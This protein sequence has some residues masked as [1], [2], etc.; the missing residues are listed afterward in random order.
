M[1]TK[2]RNKIAISQPVSHLYFPRI[3][4]RIVPYSYVHI[5]PKRVTFV[6]PAGSE[7]FAQPRMP[8]AART[9]QELSHS[10]CAETSTEKN[11]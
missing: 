8:S 6:F 4:P 9:A 1:I 7:R 5:H 10:V 11:T 2:Y 3:L